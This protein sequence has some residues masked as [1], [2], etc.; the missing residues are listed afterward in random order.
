[1]PDTTILSISCVMHFLKHPYEAGPISIVI[2]WRGQAQRGQV[3]SPRSHRWSDIRAMLLTRCSPCP[4]PP[5]LFVNKL[6]H[7][8]RQEE[9]A[10][11]GEV[12][13]AAL[14]GK[15]TCHLRYQAWGLRS[16]LPPPPACPFGGRHFPPPLQFCIHIPKDLQ[17]CC[18]FLPD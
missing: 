10:C 1:M 2:L 5:G 4:A 16:T 17:P 11:Q 3:M 18:F 7:R 15:A 8:R 9:P 12:Q 14:S 6:A 13:V